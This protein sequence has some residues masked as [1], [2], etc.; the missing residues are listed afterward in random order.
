VGFD[1]RCG[2]PPAEA[3]QCRLEL[4]PDE[5]D[6]CKHSTASTHQKKKIEQLLMADDQ[7][8]GGYQ[9]CVATAKGAAP[10]E[11]KC[12]GEYHRRCRKRRCRP[13]CG[14]N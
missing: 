8:H 4:V 7:R 12:D 14:W 6:E 1:A 9:L 13:G 10:E 2:G 3:T 11:K 5:N